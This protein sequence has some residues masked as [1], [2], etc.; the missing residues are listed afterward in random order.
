MN[1]LKL[2]NTELLV[3][4]ADLEVNRIGGRQIDLYFIDIEPEEESLDLNSLQVGDGAKFEGSG[5]AL[6]V[7]DQV[8]ELD[9][10]GLVELH[11][12]APVVGVEGVSGHAVGQE[13]PWEAEFGEDVVDRGW[14]RW[15]LGVGWG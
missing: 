11:H 2:V 4:E 14:W 5:D 12:E 8:I 13:A 10:A 6:L 1:G 9:I 15:R 3:D 7:V